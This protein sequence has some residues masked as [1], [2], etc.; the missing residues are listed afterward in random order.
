MDIDVFVSHHTTSSLHIAEAIVNRLESIGIRCWYA[1]RNTEGDYAGS[2]VRAINSCRIFLLIL[3]KPASESV[4]VL[5]EIDMV[6]KRLSKGE[7]VSLVPF[8]VADDEI[9]DAAQYY[10]GRMHWIDAMNPPMYQRVDELVDKI[11]QMLGASEEKTQSAAPQSNYRLIAKVPQARDCF[12]GRDDLL[13]EIERTFSCGNRILFLE[14][15]GG[16]GKSELAK[17]YAL[18]HEDTFHKILFVTYTNGLCSLVCDKYQIQIEGL[19]QEQ[20]EED[21]AF[22]ER[23][24]QVFRTLADEHTLMIVDNYDVDSDPDFATFTEGVHKIIFT[25]RNSHSGY[26]AIQ[27]RSIHDPNALLEIFEQNYGAPLEEEDKPYILDLFQRIEYHTYTV[28]LIAKQMEASFLSG[29][30]MLNLFLSGTMGRDLTETVSGRKSENTAF[31]HI[32]SVFSTSNLSEEEKQILRELSVIGI[33]GIPANRLKEWAGLSSFEV[34]N[35][36]IKRSWIRRESGQRLSLHPLVGEVI[37]EMLTPDAANC[38]DFLGRMADFL[39]HAWGRP[40]KENAAVTDNVLSVAQYFQPIDF[41][42]L[43]VWYTIPSFLWQVGKFEESVQLGII[44]YQSCLAHFGEASMETGFTAKVLGGCYFN[45][46][47]EQESIPWYKQGLQSMLLSQQPESEDLAMSYEKVARCYTWEYEQDFAKAKEY[48]EQSLQIRVRLKEAM[49]RGEAHPYIEKRENFDLFKCEER[50]GESY[51]EMGRMYQAM[52]EWETAL[53]MVQKQEQILTA[54]GYSGTNSL[55]FDYYDE[56]VCYY[57]MGQNAR[58]SGKEEEAS[59]HF[60]TARDL[61]EKAL[62]I[63]SRMRGEVALDTIRNEEYLADTYVA[64]GQLGDA[65]NYYMAVITAYSNLLGENSPHIDRIKKK[66]DFSA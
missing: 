54:H 48:F 7:D 60:F 1:P 17:Q 35:K 18:Q 56:G 4:H 5:N 63:N 26:P 21:P 34:V 51:M 44:L 64:L 58:K 2:I 45:T 41:C 42:M 47:R 37:R 27:V 31:G 46:G 9:S 49:E 55:A 61:F 65:S 16:I 53:A 3:N 20:G 25:T 22:F 8:H 36:L 43:D 29:E 33:T 13:E 14:G 62:E 24:M 59:Q 39:F 11:S 52:E 57:H 10:L 66:M 28:E 23:K 38:H 12:L 32:C 19:E 30:E 6:V 15:I 50:I 40:V